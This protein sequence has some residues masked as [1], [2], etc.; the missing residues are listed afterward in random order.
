MELDKVVRAGHLLKVLI[1]VVIWLTTLLFVKAKRESLFPDQVF[2][3]GLQ[4]QT[5]ST[6][7]PLGNQKVYQRTGKPEQA[8]LRKIAE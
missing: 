7:A 8:M 2:S 3:R 6:Q 5:R 4:M 1:S